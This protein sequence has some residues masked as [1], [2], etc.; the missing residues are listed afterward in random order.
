[1]KFV[2]YRDAKNE[3]RWKL[4]AANGNIVADSG[5]GYKNKADC[6]STLASIKKAVAEAPI[7]E[8]S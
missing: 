4:A 3:Y 7:E 2:L 5:E 6:L 8:E 1:M